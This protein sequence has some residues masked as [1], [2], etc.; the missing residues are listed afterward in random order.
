MDP[1]RDRRVGLGLGL[2][3]CVSPARYWNGIESCR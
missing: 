3:G 1:V 2:R